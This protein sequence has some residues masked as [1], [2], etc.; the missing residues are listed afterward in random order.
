MNY[1]QLKSMT[2]IKKDFFPVFF[3]IVRDITKQSNIVKIQSYGSRKFGMLRRVELLI[4]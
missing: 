4:F 3:S 2:D 1:D